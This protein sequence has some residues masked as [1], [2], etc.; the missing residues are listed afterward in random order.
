MNATY[1]RLTSSD[2]VL[3][4]VVYLETLKTRP[5]ALEP[6]LSGLRRAFVCLFVS[7]FWFLKELSCYQLFT[8]VSWMEKL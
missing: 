5:M 1:L 6:S 4:P 3:M 2:E 8:H 7:L